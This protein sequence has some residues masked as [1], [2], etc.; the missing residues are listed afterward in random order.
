MK[1]LIFFPYRQ[2]CQVVMDNAEFSWLF[3][4]R[5]RS[6]LTYPNSLSNLFF[7]DN[8]RPFTPGFFPEKD[9]LNFMFSLHR[10]KDHLSHYIRTYQHK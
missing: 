2:M 1:Q 8:P 5:H 10:I 3:F 7:I 4:D 9:R 6:A